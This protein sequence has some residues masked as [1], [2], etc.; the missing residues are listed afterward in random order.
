M[1][2]LSIL[3]VGL[4]FSSTLDLY[5]SYM[6]AIHFHLNATQAKIHFKASLELKVIFRHIVIL[7]HTTIVTL[8]VFF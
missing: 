2:F 7:L 1:Y 3:S 6:V 5:K 4:V 8:S